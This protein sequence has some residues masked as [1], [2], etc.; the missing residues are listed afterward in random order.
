MKVIKVG[1][2]PDAEI[3]EFG[4]MEIAVIERPLREVLL[5]GLHPVSLTRSLGN[6]WDASDLAEAVAE[7]LNADDHILPGL[8]EFGHCAS[9]SAPS[10]EKCYPYAAGDTTKDGALDAL[11]ANAEELYF[12]DELSYPGLIEIARRRLRGIWNGA[13]AH[14]LLTNK[15]P[16]FND[17]RRFLKEKGVSATFK[18]WRDLACFGLGESLSVDD[19]EHDDKLLVN[20]GIPGTVNFRRPGAL[21]SFT[22]AEGIVSLVPRID[23][24][25][26]RIPAPGVESVHVHSHNSVRYL[27]LLRDGAIRFIP[28]LPLGESAQCREMARAISQEVAPGRGKYCFSLEIEAVEKLVPRASLLFPELNYVKGCGKSQTSAS[29]RPNLMVPGYTVGTLATAKMHNYSLAELLSAHGEKV[30]GTKAEMLERLVGAIV[31]LYG[32]SRRK[33]DDYFRGGFLKLPQRTSGGEPFA[34]PILDAGLRNNVLAIYVLKHLRGS[35]ILSPD[36]ENSAY[37]V[38]DLARALLAQRVSAD[39]LFVRAV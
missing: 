2:R 8:K 22:N 30:S 10:Q 18:T 39:G 16:G 28:D 26:M 33:L 1:L 17:Q 12:I 38:E 5:G 11:K 6:Y 9:V 25:D 36:W 14:Q 32:K 19:F 3:P 23:R 27:C 29:I 4:R 24:F 15:L 37:T 34:P 21:G 31:K 20:I 13:I 35:R 7:R